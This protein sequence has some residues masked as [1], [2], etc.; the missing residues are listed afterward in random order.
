MTA[1]R[2]PLDTRRLHAALDVVLTGGLLL[3]REVGSTNTELRALITDRPWGGPMLLSAEHQVA[4]R[5]RAGHEWQTP[6][7]AAL[8]LSVAFRPERSRESWGWLPLLTGLA[9]ARAVEQVTGLTPVLKWPNDVLL[10]DPVPVA[11]WGAHRKGV[12]ILN[13]TVGDV[14]IAGVGI[15]VDQSPAEL[16]VPHAGSLRTAGAPGM[17]R[18]A[19]AIAVVHEVLALAAG[20]RD[21]AVEDEV[22][23]RC[24]T[25]GTEIEADLPGGERLTGR[26]V[27]IDEHAALAVA[28]DA[29][30]RTLTAG[31]LRHVR[32]RGELGSGG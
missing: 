19:L 3:R 27:R 9:V 16:P 30:E 25:L 32:P 2:R 18:T 23:A 17:D 4:G 12:G 6:S 15:N 10:P 1:S 13:E 21:R 7:G 5:G 8:T 31:D 22:R 24:V 14:V 26:A 20:A 29:G 28:T 11:G